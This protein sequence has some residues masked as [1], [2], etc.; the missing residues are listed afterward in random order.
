MSGIGERKIN[1]LPIQFSFRKVGTSLMLYRKLINSLKKKRIDFF[2]AY[3]KLPKL[4]VIQSTKAQTAV[5]SLIGT[6]YL[7]VQK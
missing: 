5:L 6:N 7:T 3:N 1:R 2:I 4:K